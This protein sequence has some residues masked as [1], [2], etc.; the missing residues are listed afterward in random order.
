MVMHYIS[1]RGA[2]GSKTFREVLLEGLAPD[3]GLYTPE[4]YPTL[5]AAELDRLR[6]LRYPELAYEIIH[7]Y[8]DDIDESTLRTIISRTYTEEIF[9]P[10]IV[11]VSH[12]EGNLHLLHTSNGPSLAFKD[13]AMQLLGNLFEHV[14]SEEGRQLNILGATSGDTGSA[15]EQAMRSKHNVRVFM[16]SPL[17]RTS[18]F[19][20]A[21]MFSILDDNIHNLTVRGVFDDCQD[22]VKAVNEDLAFKQRHHIGAVN[23]INWGR[24]VA[25]VVYYF[26]GYFA[27]TKSNGERISVSVPSGNFGNILAAHVAKQM[28]L[29]LDRLILA[30]NENDVLQEFF[31]TGVYRVRPS[32]AV[33]ATSSP[34]M[35]IAKASNFERFAFDLLG[36][37]AASTGNAFSGLNPDTPWDLRNEPSH[38]DMG[39]YGFLAGTSSHTERVATIR[40]L[41]RRLGVLVD[42]HT[43]DGINVARAS[44]VQGPILC[45]E[46]ALPAKFAATIVEAIGI[47]PPRPAAFD[48]IESRPQRHTTIELNLGALK[49]YIA[50]ITGL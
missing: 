22:L 28:G 6:P 46:T 47:E 34:S 11:P 39:A 26:H 15:A 19:Q 33:E 5:D 2:G 30:T 32:A 18:P 27:L 7:K 17:G 14:L 29:P 44:G 38:E 37:N 50:T 8:A 40:D 12:L 31:T 23:S 3:G 42:P 10:G 25:Q 49:N 41:H 36:R 45:G 13:M 35:D 9:G 21:Q 43:A 48:A 4:A 20:A 16:L 1:T 24:I